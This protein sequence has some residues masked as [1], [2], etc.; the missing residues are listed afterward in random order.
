MKRWLSGEHFT[1]LAEDIGSIP[2]PYM[3]QLITT[4]NSSCRRNNTLSW[5][6]RVPGDTHTHMHTHMDIFNY[7]FSC[8]VSSRTLIDLFALSFLICEVKLPTSQACMRTR[9]CMKT[10]W[11]VVPV[12]T[13][14]SSSMK[15][16]CTAHQS[17]RIRGHI[18]PRR[19]W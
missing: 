10:G 13:Q 2:G 4:C 6:G 9:A 18:L 12:P 8:Y 3:G 1:A 15:A 11:C 7:L 19:E 16:F 17:N 14:S 5:P